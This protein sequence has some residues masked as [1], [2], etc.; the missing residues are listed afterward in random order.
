LFESLKN[1]LLTLGIREIDAESCHKLV[2]IGSDGASANVAKKGLKGIVE[3]RCEWMFW[4]WCLAHRLELAVKDALKATVFNDVDDML[5]KLY[6]IYE[7]SPKKCR[8]L[9][10][11]I[12]DLKESLCMEDGG[13]KPVRA[14]GSR[15][16]SHKLSALKR[17]LSKYGAYSSHL[18]AL[19]K[20]SSVKS[21]DRAKFSGYCNRW[22]Q[23]KYLLGCAF[24]VDILTP[25]AIF[26]K[27]MQ[28]N[29]LDIV[30]A[31]TSL[32]RTVKE[33][34]RLR[35]SQLNK[36]PVYS[37]TMKQIKDENGKNVYQCQ[38]LKYFND[39]IRS[40]CDKVL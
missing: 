35:T 24:F 20:D 30:A 10:E 9:E 40:F 4:M 11:I 36:W 28:S 18:I 37:A 17:I 5:V 32:L 34:E 39:L 7:K 33:T 19:S 1:A 31:L 38:E 29:E 22:L 13:V 25:C 3:S 21:S 26:S 12:L 2:S 14:S 8:E 6:Y 27:I 15:W 23:A 16:V